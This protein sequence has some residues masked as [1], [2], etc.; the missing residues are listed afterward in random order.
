MRSAPKLGLLQTGHAARPV[1][2]FGG[3]TRLAFGARS[4]CRFPMADG[5]RLAMRCYYPIRRATNSTRRPPPPV[6][7]EARGDVVHTCTRMVSFATSFV[8]INPSGVSLRSTTTAKFEGC[9]TRVEHAGHNVLATTRS[10]PRV[11]PRSTRRRQRRTLERVPVAVAVREGRRATKCEQAEPHHRV[12]E[13]TELD[14][15]EHLFPPVRRASSRSAPRA[16]RRAC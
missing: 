5:P 12:H 8:R 3:A 9:S 11:H 1:R 7:H 16:S 2:C 6:R 4:A 15:H 14:P 13:R 10:S